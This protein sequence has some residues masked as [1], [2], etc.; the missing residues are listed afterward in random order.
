MTMDV[1]VEIARVL[2]VL[3]SAQLPESV[4]GQLVLIPRLVTQML[5]VKQLLTR[6]ELAFVTLVIAKE[7][8]H[9]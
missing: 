5:T 4:T 9:W 7:V 3:T 2:L 8:V 6:T 1:Y